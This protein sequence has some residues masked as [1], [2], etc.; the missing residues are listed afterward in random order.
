MNDKANDRIITKDDK[1]L[2]SLF[3]TIDQLSASIEN[4]AHNLKPGLEGGQYLTDKEVSKLLK[5]SRRSLQDY[6]TQGKIPFY[7]IG[8]KIL[9]RTGDIG[10]FMEEHYRDRRPDKG[11]TCI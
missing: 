1:R 5:I 2:A 6:R 7:R 8:E 11:F 3:Q 9:Y 10:R 4:I